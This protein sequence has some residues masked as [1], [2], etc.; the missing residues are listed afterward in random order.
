MSSSEKEQRQEGN[1]LEP[2][3]T[4]DSDLSQQ[5]PDSVDSVPLDGFMKEI[6]KK[7]PPKKKR[8]GPGW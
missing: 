7:Y 8:Y 4:P 3:T 2:Q 1:E 6:R 5:T